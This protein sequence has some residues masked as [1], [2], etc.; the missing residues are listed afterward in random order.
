[1][2][3][4]LNSKYIKTKQNKRLENKFFRP[5]QVLY[6]VGKQVYKL[7]LPTKWKIYDVFH[8]SLLEQ[9]TTR[10]GQVDNKAL[11]KPKKEL[12]F[13]AKNNKEYEFQVIIDSKVYGPQANNNQMP[14]LYYLVL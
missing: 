12:E 1:M 5:F 8:V 7:E 13:K 4:W 10:K 14:D 9:D 11:P 3:V 2:K 6:P